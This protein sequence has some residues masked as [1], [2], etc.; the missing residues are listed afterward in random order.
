[1]LSCWPSRASGTV[2]EKGPSRR[3]PKALPWQDTGQGGGERL[4]LML[5]WHHPVMAKGLYLGGLA[6]SE[7]FEPARK[8]GKTRVRKTAPN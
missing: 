5:T 3:L 4:L 1:M 8:K 2:G 7:P 6:C